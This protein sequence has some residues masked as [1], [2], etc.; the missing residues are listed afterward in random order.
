MNAVFPHRLAQAAAT[1]GASVLQIATDCVFSGRAGGYLESSPHDALDVYGKT[2]SLGEVVGRHVHHLRTSIVGPER[3]PSRASLL[4]WFLHH[5]L[6]SAVQGFT[7]HRWNGVTTLHFARICD[8]AI[9]TGIKLPNCHHL[10]PADA[11]SKHEMLVLFARAFNR[12]DLTIEARPTSPLIDRTLRT[13]DV[14]L[15]R[16][17]WR[18]AG[19]PEPPTVAEMIDELAATVHAGREAA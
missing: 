4:E 17:L 10:V 19:Y 18:A 6:A 2:K 13:R 8:A 3:G 5:P 7:T 14:E 1:C 15:G 16:E 12:L 9:R 11:V